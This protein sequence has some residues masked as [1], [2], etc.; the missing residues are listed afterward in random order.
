MT[1]RP[2]AVRDH[3]TT[4]DLLAVTKQLVTQK[5]RDRENVQVA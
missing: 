5:C 4:E 3:V 2:P 1:K